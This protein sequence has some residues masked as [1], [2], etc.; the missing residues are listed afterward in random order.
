MRRHYE[1]RP[2]FPHERSRVWHPLSPRAAQPAQA[3]SAAALP[4]VGK[5]CPADQACKRDPLVAS[6]IIA[7]HSVAGRS[8]TGVDLELLFEHPFVMAQLLTFRECFIA[9]GRDLRPA[10]NASILM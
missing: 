5:T 1:Y 8:R 3:R 9:L 2:R 4:T 6:P 7:R 10:P